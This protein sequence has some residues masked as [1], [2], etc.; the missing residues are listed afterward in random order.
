MAEVIASAYVEL[1][2]DA[3]KF[4]T[5]VP[6][7]V[8]AA[9]SRA[10]AIAG[11]ASA[12]ISRSLSDAAGRADTALAAVDGNG[13]VGVR[14]AAA[15]AGASIVG[16]LTDAG[17]RSDTA[18]AK[19]D[20]NGLAG[21]KAAAASA[22]T[23]I[24]GDL[25]AAGA[26][27][28]TA[29]AK[30][31][32]SG[33]ATVKTGAASAAT[34]IEGDLTGAG[35]RSDVA[36]AK[37][38]GYGFFAAQSGAAA[39]AASIAGE[40][41][42]A[43]VRSDAALAAVDGAGFVAAK[44]AAA[45]ASAKVA[46][47][48]T[49]AG[50]QADAALTKVDG[51]GFTKVK[52][53]AA[54]AGDKVGSE[55]KKGAAEGESA[56]DKLGKNVGLTLAAT[57]AVKFFK[58]SADAASNLNES[59]SKA[60]VLF[61][62]SASKITAF[63]DS[64]AT[65]LGQSKQQAIE[66]AGTFAL[67]GKSAGLAGDDLVDFSTKFVTLAGDMASFSNT[68][69]EQAIEAIGAALR[70][71][72][73]PIRAY[74]V[75]LDDATLKQ[76]A[77]ELGIF[78]GVGS[79]TAQQR[80]LAA[81]KSILEQT[82]A[83]QGD[84]ARTSDGMA[85]QARIASAEFENFKAELG[86]ALIPIV[87]QLIGAFKT[88]LDIFQALPGPVQKIIVVAVA[89]GAVLLGLSSAFQTLGVSAATAN[90]AIAAIAI[91]LISAVALYRAFTASKDAAREA[92]D[93]FVTSLKAEEE[94]HRGVL[95]AQ[96][97]TT[98]QNAG[99]LDDAA[100]FGLTAADI[101]NVIQGKTVP[102]YEAFKDSLDSARVN[103]RLFQAGIEQQAG[104]FSAAQ[105]EVAVYNETLA[106]T[107]AALDHGVV[108]GYSAEQQTK[109]IIAVQKA[110][111][112]GAHLS[113][114]ATGDLVVSTDALV[115]AG[116]N[117]MQ[118]TAA[119]NGVQLA[120]Q[121]ATLA[122]TRATDAQRAALDTVEQKYKDAESALQS[123]VDATLAAF[124]AQLQLEDR[125]AA[126][127]DAINAYTGL[128]WQ[129]IAGTYEGTN[130][131]GDLA[132]AARG[133]YEAALAQAAAAAEVA[134]KQAEASGAT[135]TAADAARVQRDS[136]LDVVATLAPDSPLRARL[137]EYINILNN[138]I[139][140]QIATDFKT[141]FS[142]NANVR[143]LPGVVVHSAEGRI[144]TGPTLSWIGEAG[145]EAVIPLT[146]PA[147][148][149][150]LLEQSGLGDLARRGRGNDV[151]VSMNFPGAVFADAT[152]AEL[153]AQRTAAALAARTLVA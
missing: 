142:G 51:G 120:F 13:L 152:N 23:A 49:D 60:Q 62:D 12:D 9:M 132:A 133:A 55:M 74:G 67:F 90:L 109:A 115:V 48:L 41:T 25:S 76:K 140:T 96:L 89:A 141:T 16:D 44:N 98:I 65:A 144:T 15:A 28:D 35:A 103:G 148:A 21:A 105:R 101:A 143:A 80:V 146:K 17:A 113:A 95:A 14:E 27:A 104:A 33:F 78:D 10:A 129:Q 1:I 57:A 145:T 147:R 22:A 3:S 135:L 26:K 153:V 117:N 150:E 52:T 81:Q 131:T 126:T 59:V 114:T 91:V 136:L 127:G 38:S 34:S 93:S 97:A 64:A 110:Y 39:A 119:V 40:L 111:V 31:D 61:G 125:T 134:T 37:V 53:A 4:Q 56:L 69:P 85:N 82:G 29:L 24:E 68:S 108:A 72:A 2:A 122:S 99:L 149:S 32:G 18:L 54:E 107:T 100:K 123:L 70:G 63:G 43:G 47:D 106:A 151:T 8:Q 102:A 77:M 83:A 7:A 128:L 121:Q 124:S 138:E 5:Q 130:A 66:A 50:A 71:E 84:F 45:S 6:A 73:E 58:D 86:T 30:V 139:P 112:D 42:G 116:F 36:L 75:L 11:Q 94:G 137:Q 46:G 92:T 118:Q 87:K 20:G 79:L 88:A 19:I